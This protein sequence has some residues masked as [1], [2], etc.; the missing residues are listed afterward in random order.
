MRPLKILVFL[1]AAWLATLGKAVSGPEIS[2]SVVGPEEVVFRWATDR[3]NDNDIPDAPA[4]AFRDDRGTIRLAATHY[5][6][7][8]FTVVDGKPKRVG[9]GIVLDSPDDPDPAKYHDHRWIAATWTDDGKE[10]HALIHHEFQGHRHAGVCAFKEYSACWYNSI[11][12]AR[13]DDGGLTFVQADPPAVVAAAPFRQDVGQGRNRGFFSPT[14]II[15]LGQYWYVLIYTTGWDGQRPGMCVFRTPDI[16]QPGLWRAWDG[17]AFNSQF[18]D[19]Y[20]SSGSPGTT[21]NCKPVTADWF[22]SVQRIDG[23]DSIIAVFLHETGAGEARSWKLAYRLSQ[24]LLTWSE[25]V[26]LKSLPY[27]GSHDCKDAFRYGYPALVDMTEQ[28]PN[29]DAVG[30]TADLFLTRFNVSGCRN[31]F[32]RDLVRY[33]IEINPGH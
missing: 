28:S 1:C 17:E 25:P 33:R 23:S 30:L 22:G 16:A 31:S 26:D 4:R 15:K 2:V 6:N 14:N 11:T 3:C 29:F 13:S 21:P 5:D 27:F 10:V 20:L 18:K 7:R 8:L 12:Y 24:D 19:P 32:D 9:C